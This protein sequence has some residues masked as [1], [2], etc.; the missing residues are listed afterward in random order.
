[1]IGRQQL[2]VASP[3]GAGA[4]LRAAAAAC[5]PSLGARAPVTTA[6]LERFGGS[7]IALTDSGTSALVLALR[8]TAG[9]HGVVAFP[10]YV[11][12]DLIAAARLAD[13]TIR[14]YDVDPR[15]LTPDLDSLR[16]VLAEGVDAVVVAHLFGFPAD[17]GAVQE[18]VGERGVPVI[19]DA[20]QGAGATLRGVRAGGLGDLSVLS[21]GRGKGTTT[22]HGGALIAL[23]D[24][25]TAPVARV[26]EQ[27]LAQGRGAPRGGGDLVVA[28]ASW[29]VGRPSVY[30][31]P[32]RLPFLHLGETVYHEAH[33]PAP[34]SAAAMALLVTVLAD[35]D[36]ATSRRQATAAVLQDEAAGARHVR[37]Y[38]PVTGGVPGYLRFP[39]LADG[40]IP[41]VPRLGIVH[42]YPRPLNEQ[43]EIASLLHPTQEPLRGARELARRLLTLPTHHLVTQGD[44]A[45]LRAWLRAA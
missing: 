4:L 2:P 12:V 35:A 8:M 29:A 13:V 30:A 45:A 41:Q 7:A 31:I 42:G 18:L 15:T 21:F 6:L 38:E 33:K 43:P 1:M 37:A 44:V 40:M 10:A 5:V 36:R 14:L 20:A 34:M 16:R 23:G 32:A 26:A 22:G 27:L 9:A 39:I 25:W 28:T 11:C 3:I 24:R 17:V 19:E